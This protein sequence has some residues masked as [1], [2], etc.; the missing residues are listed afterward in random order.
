MGDSDRRT[1][2]E[3]ICDE[4]AAIDG[5]TMHEAKLAEFLVEKRSWPLDETYAAIHRGIEDP[6]TALTRGPGYM[7]SYRGNERV[8]GG[9]RVG[10]YD[11]VVQVLTEHWAKQRQYLNVEV[12]VTAT[13]GRRGAGA[14]THPDVTLRCNPNGRTSSLETDSMLVTFEVETAVGFDVR[15]VYQAFE[16]GRGSD[17]SYVVF[18]ER[19]LEVPEFARAEQAAHELGV[20]LITYRKPGLWSSWD[21]LYRARFR[22]P[23]ESDRRE[24]IRT[25]IGE[26]I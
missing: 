19:R 23:S 25:S 9:G 24:F 22:E 16:Q 10:L 3:I 6:D 21:Q 1:R 20:G 2:V 7:I 5:N 14:W 12:L 26:M 11:D 18:P 8:A 4:L 17:Y 15:S 13:S